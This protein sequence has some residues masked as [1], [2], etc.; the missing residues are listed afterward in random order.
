M[1]GDF[2]SPMDPNISSSCS[3]SGELFPASSSATAAD[4]GGEGGEDTAVGCAYC[5]GGEGCEESW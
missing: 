3:F 2:C 4:S 1:F 5:L